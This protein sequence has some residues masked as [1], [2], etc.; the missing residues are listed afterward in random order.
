MIIYCHKSSLIS[1]NCFTRDYLSPQNKF[2]GAKLRFMS[3]APLFNR[4]NRCTLLLWSV[5]LA[6]EVDATGL[7][8]P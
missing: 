6:C 7:H 1:I 2:N 4:F 5:P 8:F 3:I